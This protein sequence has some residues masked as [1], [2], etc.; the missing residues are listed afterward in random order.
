MLHLLNKMRKDGLKI[1][2]MGNKHTSIEIYLVRTLLKLTQSLL[3]KKKKISLQ[4]KYV[5]DQ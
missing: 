4:Q 2:F 3:K 5:C 1:Q